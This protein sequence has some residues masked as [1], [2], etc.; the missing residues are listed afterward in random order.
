MRSEEEIRKKI[1]EIEEFISENR[2]RL[3]LDAETFFEGAKRALEWVLKERE[4]I[5]ESRLCNVVV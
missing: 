4:K 5:Y 1:V 3:S 2:V